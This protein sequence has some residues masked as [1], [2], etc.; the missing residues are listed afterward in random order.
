MTTV[1]S[2]SKLA[3]T[4]QLHFKFLRVLSGRRGKCVL[5]TATDKES[6]S[7]SSFSVFRS[8]S[9]GSCPAVH[10]TG[11]P[12]TAWIPQHS[13]SG[14]PPEEL[15]TCDGSHSTSDSY[16]LFSSCSVCNLFLFSLFFF[17]I[18]PL[19]PPLVECMKH[20]EH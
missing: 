9:Q 15:L 17:L 20:A 19:R 2:F 7:L 18:V 14:L 4:F 8:G 12:Y 13:G 16:R 3:L 11:R 10:V 5:K 1:G 6:W